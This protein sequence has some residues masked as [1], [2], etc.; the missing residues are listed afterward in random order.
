[1]TGY[2]N[3]SYTLP[4]QLVLHLNLCVTSVTAVMPPGLFSLPLKSSCQHALLSRYIIRLASNFILNT[5]AR[6]V[7]NRG[8]H[9]SGPTP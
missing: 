8:H 6:S 9:G 2:V 4:C 3:N 7:V 1:M 5:P